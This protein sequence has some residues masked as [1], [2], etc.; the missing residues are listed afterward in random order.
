MPKIDSPQSVKSLSDKDLTLLAKEVRKMI[1][2]TVSRNGGHLSSNLGVIELTIA[3]HSVFSS[4]DD[5]IVWDVGH[6]CYA[7]KLLTGRYDRFSTI[8]QRGGLS[9]FPR[10]DESEHDVFGTGH[11]STSISAAYGILKAKRLKGDAGKVIAV[12]GDGAM[13]G[14]MVYEALSNVG[15]GGED[16]I[17]IL[18]D[19]KMSISRN[20]GAVSKY[21]SKLAM[22]DDYQSLKSRTE[23]LVQTIPLLGKRLY[24]LLSR[25]KRAAKKFLLSDNLFGDLGFQYVGPLDGHKT[26]ELKKV[27]SSV[28]K[29]SSPVVVHVV[30]KKGCGF[31]YAENDPVL[32]H[33]VSPFSQEDGKLEK[34]ESTS[35]TEAFSGIM[36]DEAASRDNLVAI[37]AAMPK[38]T[39]LYAFSQRYPKRFFDV[40]IAEEHAV[41]FAAGLATEGI[42]PV[43]AIYSTF[44]QRAV[45]QLIHDTALQGLHV[46]FALDR[47]GIVP[48]DGETHQGVFDIAMFRSLPGVAILAPASAEEMRVLFSWALEAKGPVIIRYPKASCPEEL[49]SFS[50]PARE[51]RG[52]F[53]EQEGSDALIVCTGGI[54]KEVLEASNILAKKDLAADIYNLRFIK[55]LDKEYFLK[56]TSPYSSIIIVEDGIRTAGI[57]EYLK[58]LLHLAHPK[59]RVSVLA[60][61]EKLFNEDAKKAGLAGLVGT[62]QEILEAAGMSARHIAAEVMRLRSIEA[63][64]SSVIGSLRSSLPY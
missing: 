8:R 13:T 20:T 34:P 55:P 25:T 22:R 49:H 14:G 32:F 19:N 7:H 26:L 9:G 27:L 58:G 43:V 64:S 54:F 42:I 38:G 56:V 52:V 47:S 30:T 51:G 11:A 57:G 2:E 29:L 60:F 1:V 16:L 24:T 17:V 33:G 63:H 48:A 40:G 10:R 46:I 28:K 53:A 44:M 36:L 59:A 45:D 18:N 50:L 41:T 37:T 6:Q 39:G 3:L 35:F 21:L 5:C 62:R 4:P 23:R 12:I 31:S 61:P 15:E